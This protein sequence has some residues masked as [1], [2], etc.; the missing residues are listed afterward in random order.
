MRH[1]SKMCTRSLEIQLLTTEILQETR[2]RC[3]SKIRA[4]MISC[5][6]TAGIGRMVMETIVLMMM[7]KTKTKKVVF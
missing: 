2:Q 3:N 5:Q 7:K 6:G 4:R 1:V